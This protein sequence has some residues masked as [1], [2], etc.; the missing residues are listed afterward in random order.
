VHK[1][2]PAASSAKP[3]G[4][5]SGQL[6]TRYDGKLGSAEGTIEPMLNLVTFDRLRTVTVQLWQETGELRDPITTVPVPDEGGFFRAFN[7]DATAEGEDPLGMAPDHIRLSADKLTL[8]ISK[9]ALS[10]GFDLDAEYATATNIKVDTGSGYF[11][12]IIDSKTERAD[13]WEITLVAPGGFGMPWPSDESIVT[14]TPMTPQPDAEVVPN[15]AA[16]ARVR[17]RAGQTGE[18]S[19]ECDWAAKFDVL[20]QSIEI[21]RKSFRPN[22]EADYIDQTVKLTAALSV[23]GK[24]QGFAPQYT[25]PPVE[26]PSTGFRTIALPQFARRV[27]LLVKFGDAPSGDVP[28]AQIFVAFATPY[29]GSQGFIDGLSARAALFGSGLPIP[30]GANA[31]V[32]TNMSAGALKLGAVFLLGL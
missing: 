22:G 30:H 6:G 13:D 29:Q 8:Y 23:D 9:T 31:I 25:E 19:F 14:L 11:F 20:A 18:I 15:A 16:R 32:I 3:A 10:P 27:T 24:G 1:G 21:D 17:L 7:Y 26:I 2:K 4:V 12:V 28:L 5:L